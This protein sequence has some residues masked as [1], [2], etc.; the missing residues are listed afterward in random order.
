MIFEENA[1]VPSGKI[2]DALFERTG[3]RIS[4]SRIRDFRAIWKKGSSIRPT[5]MVEYSRRVRARQSSSPS[6]TSSLIS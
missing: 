6:I 4:S 5:P 1:S 3:V 2:S